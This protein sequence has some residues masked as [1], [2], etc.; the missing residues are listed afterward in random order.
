[1]EFMIKRDKVELLNQ[2]NQ[3]K[4]MEEGRLLR[5]KYLEKK[6]VF[7]HSSAFAITTPEGKRLTEEEF[8]DYLKGAKL[9]RLSMEFNAHYCRGLLEA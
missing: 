8:S 1:M 6:K 5:E 2:V 7:H 3:E 9:T 4:L